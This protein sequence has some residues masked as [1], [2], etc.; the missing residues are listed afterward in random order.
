MDAVYT[1]QSVRCTNNFSTHR[2]K[3]AVK[4][5]KVSVVVPPG[6]AVYKDVEIECWQLVGR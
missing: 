1:A 5:V 2:E 3:Q 6:N 4:N